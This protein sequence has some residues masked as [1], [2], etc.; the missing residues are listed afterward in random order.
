MLLVPKTGDQISLRLEVEHQF[1]CCT[2]Y[3]LGEHPGGRLEE[4]LRNPG[5]TALLLSVADGM[6][7]VGQFKV[8]V[9]R[10]P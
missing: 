8:V 10:K 7:P 5:D 6:R 4:Y 9:A 1:H 2:D 3:R